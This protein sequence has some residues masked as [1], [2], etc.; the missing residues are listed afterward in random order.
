MGARQIRNIRS[1]QGLTF[2]KRPLLAAQGGHSSNTDI[3]KV[4]Q[5]DVQSSF[6]RRR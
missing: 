3:G 4:L 6:R 1:V 2:Q 5:K